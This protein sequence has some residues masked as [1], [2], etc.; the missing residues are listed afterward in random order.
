MSTIL[1]NLIPKRICILFSC[2]CLVQLCSAQIKVLPDA[3][4]IVGADTDLEPSAKLTIN[5]DTQGF[6]TPRVS[7]EQ[8][9]DIED[10]AQGLLVYVTDPSDTVRGF[11]YFDGNIWVKLFG[12]CIAP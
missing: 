11:Y 7:D 3:T 5:S 10:P 2:I 6:L 1:H 9:I 8:R 12:G 4:V